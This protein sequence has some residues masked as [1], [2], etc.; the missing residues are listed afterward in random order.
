MGGVSFTLR[1]LYFRGKSLWYSITRKPG[2]FIVSVQS[3]PA[4]QLTSNHFT[5]V[6]I[7]THIK[8]TPVR[9]ILQDVYCVP[10][11]M[12]NCGSRPL[13]TVRWKKGSQEGQKQLTA[14]TMHEHQFVR[15]K[16]VTSW[17]I[18]PGGPTSTA[19]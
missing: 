16:E 10:T 3:K 19:V 1:P 17:N 5:D 4:V 18:T 13:K 15:I 6:A 2:K 14:P 7:A 12:R 8:K 11:G 9:F